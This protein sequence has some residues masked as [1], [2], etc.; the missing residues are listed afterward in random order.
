M[1]ELFW[2]RRGVKAKVA[3]LAGLSPNHLSEILRRRR[4]VSLDRAYAL[5]RASKACRHGISWMTWINSK[6]TSH[7]AF[8]G[9]PTRK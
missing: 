8:Y 5:E 9:K 7:V 2:R 1:K 6:T 3:R 4:G